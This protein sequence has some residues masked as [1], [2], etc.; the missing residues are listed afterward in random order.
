MLNPIRCP[1]NFE[2]QLV[3]PSTAVSFHAF[4]TLGLHSGQSES[5]VSYVWSPYVYSMGIT[6]TPV[7]SLNIL[8]HIH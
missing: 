8:D 2:T 1:Q 6:T 5:N 3:F 4:G 7:M